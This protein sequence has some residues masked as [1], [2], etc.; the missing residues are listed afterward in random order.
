[1]HGDTEGRELNQRS[2]VLHLDSHRFTRLEALALAADLPVGHLVRAIV[3]TSLDS[4]LLSS[5]LADTLEEVAQVRQQLAS[6]E[7][8]PVSSPRSTDRLQGRLPI[9]RGS[10]ASRDLASP[11]R[12]LHGEIVRVLQERGEP[13]TTAEIAEEIR[14]RGNYSA[15]RTGQPPTGLTVSRRVSNP[16]YKSLFERNGRKIRLAKVTKGRSRTQEGA[17]KR[18]RVGARVK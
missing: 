15:P 3:A 7:H 4:T 5:L 13:M 1:M 10:S 16:S 8:G 12:G 14:R 11:L 6:I 2:I 9:E 18:A 17:G